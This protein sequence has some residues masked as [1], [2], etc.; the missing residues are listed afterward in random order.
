MLKIALVAAVLSVSTQAMAQEK[1]LGRSGTDTVFVWKNSDAQSEA[2]K[3][4]SAGVHKTNPTLV[5]RL[6]S[7]MV[8][9]GT[10]AVVTDG[11]MFS[12]TVLIT[13]GKN[14][15]CRGVIPNEDLR[16]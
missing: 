14:S 3:L 11:G 8:D 16:S 6:M 10:K 7:C 1:T 12:S 4:I 15:G 13:S 2:F 5:F 9:N